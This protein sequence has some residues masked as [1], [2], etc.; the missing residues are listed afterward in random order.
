MPIRVASKARK[1][2]QNFAG[3]CWPLLDPRNNHPLAI[4]PRVRMTPATFLPKPNLT[5]KIHPILA[6]KNWNGLSSEEY[7]LIK[8]A[9]RLATMYM[10]T[11]A[12]L[13]FF[14][15]C[16]FGERVVDEDWKVYIVNESPL[17]SF[18]A[19]RVKEMFLD[20]DGV[21]KFA[22]K[23]TPVSGCMQAHRWEHLTRDEKDHV[24][25]QRRVE[26]STPWSARKSLKHGK[27]VDRINGE[28]MELSFS[29]ATFADLDVY[30]DPHVEPDLF[31][32]DPCTRMTYCTV[33]LAQDYV[34]DLKRSRRS[35]E[36]ILKDNFRI[37]VTLLHELAHAVEVGR[38]ELRLYRAAGEEA[39]PRERLAEM[40][41]L[42]EQWVFGGSTAD[43]EVKD[44]RGTDC[45]PSNMCMFSSEWPVRPT[46]QVYHL[47]VE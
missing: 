6:F 42:L 34:M 31:I 36:E 3:R 11:P 28:E 24:K 27:T 41:C 20:L 7:D 1:R 40:G 37:T 14:A 29:A 19:K 12:F 33:V 46:S 23:D 9:L 21:V 43:Y 10:A 26:R 16:L 5:C 47:P 30:A 4:L 44:P 18:K 8:P 35:P 45:D 17:T 32:Q 22:F 39:F 2:L 38:P 15:T 25:S 13:E